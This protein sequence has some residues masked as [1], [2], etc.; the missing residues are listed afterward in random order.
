MSLT[1]YRAAP[2]RGNRGRRGWR[3]VGR[4]GHGVVVMRLVEGWCARCA[5]SVALQPKGV[6]GWFLDLVAIAR[7]PHPTPFRTRP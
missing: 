3:R 2:P 7:V 5:A 1:S 4:R 6:A